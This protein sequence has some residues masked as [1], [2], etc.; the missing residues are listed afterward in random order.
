MYCKFNI[1]YF[2]GRAS[3]PSNVFLDL[4]ILSLCFRQSI[5]FKFF[6]FTGF[7]VQEYLQVRQK[8]S[9]FSLAK[10]KQIFF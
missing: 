4:R 2:L 8:M 10:D 7:E 1:L 9:G 6:D 5:Y 3:F